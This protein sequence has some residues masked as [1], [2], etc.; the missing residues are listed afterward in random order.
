ML[1]SA[2]HR[3]LRL[4]GQLALNTVNLTENDYFKRRP[5]YATAAALALDEDLVRNVVAERIAWE[6]ASVP[7]DA[8]AARIGSALAGHRVDGRGGAHHPGKGRPLADRRR[9]R[10]GR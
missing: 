7:R 10:A 3:R 6:E 5:M 1:I 8:A 2:H 9:G 4:R